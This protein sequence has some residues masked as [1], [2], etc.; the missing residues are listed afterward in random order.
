MFKQCV[1]CLCTFSEEQFSE[2]KPYGCIPDFFRGSIL[3]VRT[4]LCG[5]TIGIE[6]DRN[7]VKPRLLQA[8]TASDRIT[9]QSNKGGRRR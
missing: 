2:L 3:E 8:M 6:H 4:C 5:V 7:P 1:V 9:V